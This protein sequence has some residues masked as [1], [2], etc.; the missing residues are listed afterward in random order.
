[1]SGAL[2]DQVGLSELLDEGMATVERAMIE[3]TDSDVQILRDASRHILSA[4]GKRIRPRLLLQSYLALDGRDLESVTKPAAAIE[5]MHT[6][7]VVHDDIN[8]HGI[9]RRGRPS[10]NALWGRTF[11]LLTGDFLFTAVYEL[12]A[13]YHNLNIDLAKAATALVEGETLQASAV[14]NKTFT[15]EAYM[16]IIAK[17]TAALFQAACAIGAKLAGANP[18]EIRVLSEFGFRLGLAFQIVDDI[19][20]L[21][22]DESKLGK[23]SGLD[24]TQGRGVAVALT[25]ANGNGNASVADPLAEIRRKMMEGNTIEKAREQAANLVESAIASLAILDDSPA[26][27]ALIELARQVIE[28]DC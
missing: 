9:L 5:L 19:L 8:D 12:M 1:M 24:I 21:V 7:S 23:T 18:R 6:A 15:R 13:P 2:I 28:R 17:K 16:E 20:D 4:G 27:S 3:A 11:A 22:E 10:V 25:D 14:K 26:K